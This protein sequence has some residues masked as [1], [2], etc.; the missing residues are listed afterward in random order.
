MHRV[1]KTKTNNTNSSRPGMPW[2]PR[3]ERLLRL[4][5]L[6][7]PSCEGPGVRCEVPS[8]EHEVFKRPGEPGVLQ[9]FMTSLQ[10]QNIYIYIPGSSK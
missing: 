7:K 3:A 8:L 9:R 1:L 5:A 4:K 6:G 10:Y 2:G